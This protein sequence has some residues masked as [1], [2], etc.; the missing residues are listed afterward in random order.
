MPTGLGRYRPAE[1]RYHV[2]AVVVLTGGLGLFAER[3]R[4]NADVVIVSEVLFDD[5][6][7]VNAS[8]GSLVGA[9]ILVGGRGSNHGRQNTGENDR[10]D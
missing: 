5:V 2:V 7:Q 1:H 4:I 6:V 10:R 9:V 3:V 8:R